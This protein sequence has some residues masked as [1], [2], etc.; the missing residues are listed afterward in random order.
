MVEGE[1]IVERKGIDIDRRR[2]NPRVEKQAHL[3]VHE[4]ALGGH[5]KDLHL[6]ALLERIENLKVQLNALDVE[7]NVLLRFPPD[8]LTSVGFLHPVHLDFLDDHVVPS[9]GRDHILSFIPDLSEHIANGVGNEAGVH[10][11]ALYDCVRDQRTHCDPADLGLIPGMIDDNDFYKAAADVQPYRLLAASEEA[12][13]TL[14][15]WGQKHI[16]TRWQVMGLKGPDA[17][18][19]APQLLGEGTA[20]RPSRWIGAGETV[21]D[22]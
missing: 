3:V 12:H 20:H 15:L 9:H 16:F 13:S 4:L 5:Q 8:D 7:R 1:G 10:H 18:S 22:T 11:F 6:Q 21:P 2:R 17:S 14:V 19:G